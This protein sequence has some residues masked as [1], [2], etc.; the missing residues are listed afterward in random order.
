M[1]TGLIASRYAKA[2]LRYVAAHGDGERVCYQAMTLEKAL[3]EVPELRQILKDP[4]AISTDRKMQLL[5]AALGEEPMCEALERFLALVAGSGRFGDLR[6]ILHD[7]SDLY[8]KSLGVHFATVT[9][10][11][12]ATETLLERIRTDLG[13]KLGGKVELQP[14][15]D[16]GL[17]GGVVVTVDGYRVDASVR[18]QLRALQNQFINKNKRIV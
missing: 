10:A 15:V 11:V 14:E 1:N 12:P 18:A 9:T 13:R 8:Y 16:P 17:L 6:F 7:F 3:S 5:Q 2:L 4:A